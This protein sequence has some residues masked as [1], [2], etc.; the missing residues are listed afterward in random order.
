MERI[1]WED[2]TLKYWSGN[3]FVDLMRNGL[4]SVEANGGDLAYCFHNERPTMYC[5]EVYHGK[6]KIVIQ[7]QQTTEGD[8]AKTAIS[9]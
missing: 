7:N 4:T 5:G 8:G 3:R 6:D 9:C 1:R 2:Y